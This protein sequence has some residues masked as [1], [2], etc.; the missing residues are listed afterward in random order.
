MARLLGAL[1]ENRIG[2]GSITGLGSIAGL[3]RGAESAGNPISRN[4][5]TASAG[6]DDAR[7]DR[8]PVRSA[9]PRV[10]TPLTRGTLERATTTL[11]TTEVAYQLFRP[12]GGSAP[13]PGVID[14]TRRDREQGARSSGARDYPWRSLAGT[15]HRTTPRAGSPRRA[16]AQPLFNFPSGIASLHGIETRLA[17]PERIA[18]APIPALADALDGGSALT[19]G[20]VAGGSAGLGVIINSSPTIVIQEAQGAELEA[21]VLETLRQ[22][23]GEIYEQW[24]REVGR[25]QRTE[26]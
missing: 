19:P 1:P 12:V 17:G 24:R 16:G 11:K 13:S 7:V 20:G 26:F 21:R 15:A 22:H 10:T 25:R 8:E 18:P 5:A 4:T 6:Y 2:L 3:R 9:A 23:G 14:E